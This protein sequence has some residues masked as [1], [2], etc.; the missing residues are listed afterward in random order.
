MHLMC[1]G[2]GVE[3]RQKVSPNRHC[4]GEGPSY[5]QHHR[6][7][8]HTGQAAADGKNTPS[9]R[10]ITHDKVSSR[11]L[12][13][14]TWRAVRSSPHRNMGRAF[15]NSTMLMWLL[16]AGIWRRWG[17]EVCLQR[18]C[19]RYVIANVQDAFE[20]LLFAVRKENSAVPLMSCAAVDLTI[21]F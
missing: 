3:V 14:T 16:Q 10:R 6:L 17:D 21:L 11:K 9:W 15:W 18:S 7:S 8:K 12:S 5:C 4:Y 1:R 20:T 13:T 19:L 2:W